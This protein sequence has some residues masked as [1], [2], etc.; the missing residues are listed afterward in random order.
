MSSLEAM[1]K[2]WAQET[3]WKRG[4]QGGIPSS[5][6]FDGRWY[7]QA[8]LAKDSSSNMRRLENPEEETNA[9][10]HFLWPAAFA[11]AEN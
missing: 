11:R 10:T 4:G 5:V 2:R 8:E 7:K 6:G 1:H 3:R 9:G